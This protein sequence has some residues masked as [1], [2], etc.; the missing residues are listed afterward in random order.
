MTGGA[1]T[2]GVTV[3]ERGIPPIRCGV[4]VVALVIASDMAW[5]L[6]TRANAVMTLFAALWRAGKETVL[7]AA[8]AL[9]I[10]M[11]A[12]QGETGGKVVE[13]AACGIQILALNTNTQE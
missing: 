5:C 4:A 2:G 11:P 10:P 6:A 13:M 12:G 1:I 9:H 3:I 7:M 8:G